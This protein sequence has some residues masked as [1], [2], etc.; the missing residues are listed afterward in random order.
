[1]SKI[2]FKPETV[3]VIS[4]LKSFLFLIPVDGKMRLENLLF[5][6]GLPKQLDVAVSVKDK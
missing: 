1:M 4:H 2:C 5:S 6:I 3:F